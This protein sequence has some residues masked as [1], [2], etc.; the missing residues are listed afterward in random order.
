MEP[1]EFIDKR[2]RNI[3]ETITAFKWMSLVLMFVGISLIVIPFLGWVPDGLSNVYARNGFG[4][5]NMLVPLYLKGEI[6][7]K[8][9]RI[10]NLEFLKGNL[11]GTETINDILRQILE[12]L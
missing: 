5:I 3:R 2:I 1:K 7:K 6:F 11:L 10:I 12:K 9:E 8:K 4:L